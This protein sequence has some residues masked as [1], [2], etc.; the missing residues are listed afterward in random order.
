MVFGFRAYDPGNPG[1][2]PLVIEYI[3]REYEI[4]YHSGMYWRVGSEERF[5]H[6]L[7]RSSKLDI[8]GSVA[9]L[10]WPVLSNYQLKGFYYSTLEQRHD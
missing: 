6:L 7:K 4:V 10:H 1:H 8:Y 2:L 9:A 5:I 3:F